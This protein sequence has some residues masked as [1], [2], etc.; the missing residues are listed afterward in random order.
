M[1]YRIWRGG[2]RGGC[3]QLVREMILIW[4]AWPLKILQVSY[5]WDNDF[6]SQQQSKVRTSDD[7][8][9][10]HIPTDYGHWFRSRAAIANLS[11]GQD[12]LTLLQFEGTT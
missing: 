5:C 2:W 6:T 10:K 9:Q 8:H 11:F 4:I 3:G 1:F 7:F 12:N